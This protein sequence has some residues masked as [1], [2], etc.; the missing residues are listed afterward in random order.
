MISLVVFVG[1][2]LYSVFT[3]VSISLAFILH[4]SPVRHSHSHSPSEEHSNTSVRAAFIHV[5]GDLLQSLG[6]LLAATIIYF[7]VCTLPLLT[8]K[9][10]FTR[11]NVIHQIKC[12]KCCRM[13]SVQHYFSSSF[14]LE[15]ACFRGC[16]G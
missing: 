16:T 12:L 10:T 11:V 3:C 1:I 13:F 9:S 7:R 5:L 6:V 2:F 8:Y 15:S 4:Q 14:V